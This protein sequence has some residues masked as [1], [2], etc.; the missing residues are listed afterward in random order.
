MI[1]KI[2]AIYILILSA[3]LLTFAQT[4]NGTFTLKKKNGYSLNISLTV[5]NGKVRNVSVD[6]WIPVN[7]SFHEYGVEGTRGDDGSTWTENG[8]TTSIEN[9]GQSVSIIKQ[10]NG[11]LVKPDWSEV[12]VLFTKNGAKYVGRIVK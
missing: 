4:G 3:T 2:L 5:K 8:S 6:E 12:K 1:K 9:D 10:K 7:K 11:F